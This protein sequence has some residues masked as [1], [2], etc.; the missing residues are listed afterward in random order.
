MPCSKGCG[1]F[2]AAKFRWWLFGYWLKSFTLSFGTSVVSGIVMSYRFGT[3]WDPF[4][5]KTVPVLG[6]LLDYEVLTAFSSK[7]DF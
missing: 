1:C 7:L 4:S 2:A 3:N 5:D 6:P